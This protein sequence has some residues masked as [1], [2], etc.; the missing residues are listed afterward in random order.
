MNDPTTM[1][2][3]VEVGE[4]GAD[5]FTA[6]MTD[7]I[8]LRTRML[9]CTPERATQIR[10]AGLMG[11][12]PKQIARNCLRM[13]GVRGVDRMSD[14]R[15]FAESMG[16][17]GR[18]VA[19]ADDY[20]PSMLVVGHA[21]GD[22]PLI[23]ANAG[24]KAMIRGYEMSPIT[25]RLWCKIGNLNDFKTAKRLRLSES[26]L[27]VDRPEGMPAEMGTM[28]EQGE[29]IT[30]LNRAKG[31][32]YTRQMFVNDDLGAFLDLGRRFGNGAAQT[33]E[34]AVYVSLT[35]NSKVGPTMS[36]SKAL[37]HTDHANLDS[38][39]GGV[40][41]QTLIDEMF[42]AMMTQLGIGEDSA[43]VTVGSA[44]VFFLAKPSVAMK[45]SAIIDAPF[46]G[47]AVAADAQSLQAPQ[48]RDIAAAR[49]IKVPQLALLAT[50]DWY[51]VSNQD[52]SPSY[53][54]AF[55]NGVQTPRTKTV[56]G[57]TVDGTT[58][59]VDMDYGIFPTGG[60]Q[61]INRNAGA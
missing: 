21:T 28:E 10:A 26:P 4:T 43:S 45:I 16:A 3:P 38:G 24:N 37:F 48:D 17:A 56:V 13:A 20:D 52:L 14:H 42:E 11:L 9:D 29:D 25:W 44:P 58:V 59:V 5:K 19:V 35:L 15:L 34:R 33:I 30:L 36:D 8:M 47:T 23:L 27:L 2:V 12:G 32:S 31:F 49:A 40:P 1:D 6:A 51:G 54:V 22:F 60:W 39:G 50:T 57:T 55:L 7:A 46:R 61:G 53:E 41:S 18:T